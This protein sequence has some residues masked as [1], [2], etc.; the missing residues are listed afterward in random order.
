VDSAA[1]L[2]MALKATGT[3]EQKLEWIRDL[4]SENPDATAEDALAA[5][6]EKKA[7]EGTLAKARRLI[8]GADVTDLIDPPPASLIEHQRRERSM[9]EAAAAMRDVARTMKESNLSKEEREKREQEQFDRE[10]YNEQLRA[11]QESDR[12]ERFEFPHSSARP[13]EVVGGTPPDKQRQPPPMT[14]AAQPSVPEDEFGNEDDPNE[15]RDDRIREG[16][17]GSPSAD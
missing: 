3:G 13:G 12:E 4:L 5:L 9:E 6:E 16:Q 14:P 1:E 15:R 2:L 7:P 10:L 11:K 17:E 8:A